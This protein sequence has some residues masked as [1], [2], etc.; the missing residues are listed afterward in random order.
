[1]E[2]GI[3]LCSGKLGRLCTNRIG[4]GVQKLCAL[5]GH[6]EGPLVERYYVQYLEC[7]EYFYA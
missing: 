6:M 1:M 2:S 5:L 3:T 7:L 4:V